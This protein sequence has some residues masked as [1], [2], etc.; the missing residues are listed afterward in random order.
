MVKRR[1]LEVVAY[2]C[3]SLHVLESNF[4]VGTIKAHLFDIPVLRVRS[5][6]SGREFRDL[7]LFRRG[8]ITDRYYVLSENLGAGERLSDRRKSSTW[9]PLRELRDFC[10]FFCFILSF[11]FLLLLEA[12][13]SWLNFPVEKMQ[14]SLI[15]QLWRTLRFDK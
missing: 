5:S 7:G 11:F 15:R 10:D 14:V 4:S 12:L 13:F 6:I 9:V 8:G 1:S 2:V 3:K